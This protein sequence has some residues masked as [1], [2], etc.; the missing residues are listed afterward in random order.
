MQTENNE[1]QE[2]L[3]LQPVITLQLPLA[4]DT[5]W[6]LHIRPETTLLDGITTGGTLQEGL[7]PKIWRHYLKG[8]KIIYLT[9]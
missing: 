4:F 5:H 7:F 1:Q 8:Y 2:L 9:D 6:P 3:P